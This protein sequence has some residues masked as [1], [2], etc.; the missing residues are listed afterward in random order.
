M[1]NIVII[2]QNEG[3]SIEK[4]LQS[5]SHVD[6]RRIWVLD[7]CT[8]SS[9]KYLEETGELYVKTPGKLTGRQ[10]STA[11]NLGLS[12]CDPECDVLFL[13]G[14]RFITSGD[15]AN[16]YTWEKDIALLL[17]EHDARD[18]IINYEKHYR[19]IHNFFYSCGVFFKREAINKILAYQSELF[20]VELQTHWG[21]EDV[22]LGDVCYYLGL[23]CDIYK[24]C[25]LNGEFNLFDVSAEAMK[26]RFDRINRIWNQQ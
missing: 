7:R 22:G 23:T 25:R 15:L 5:I 16:L 4:M 12:L 9:E 17:L 26:I 1:I 13:D 24:G 21:V 3:E 6:A 10:T 11:R 8:D 2:G 19:T 20:P 14:D 18:E